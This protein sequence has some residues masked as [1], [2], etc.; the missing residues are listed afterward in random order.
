MKKNYLP[1]LFILSPP[2]FDSTQSDASP[3]SKSP[4]PSLLE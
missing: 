2:N 4:Y 1:F 3:S